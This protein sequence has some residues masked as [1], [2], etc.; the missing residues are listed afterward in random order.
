MFYCFLYS[1]CPLPEVSLY[2]NVVFML[3]LVSTV[4]F[5]LHPLDIKEET[6]KGY[7]ETCY[8]QMNVVAISIDMC[9]ERFEL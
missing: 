2:K 9:L 3:F 4:F 1:E 8:S 7:K 5:C 6:E